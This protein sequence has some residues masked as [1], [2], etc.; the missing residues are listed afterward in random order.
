MHSMV[1]G[2]H[3]Y[4][5]PVSH[6]VQA[7]KDFDEKTEALTKLFDQLAFNQCIVFCN[8][9]ARYRDSAELQHC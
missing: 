2:V 8:D 5:L 3:Q 6:N 9:R 1:Q 4:Y 7:F